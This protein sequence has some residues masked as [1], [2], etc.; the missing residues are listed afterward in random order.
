MDHAHS[1]L[2]VIILFTAIYQAFSCEPGPCFDSGDF[3]F[4]DYKDSVPFTEVISR[5]YK[6]HNANSLGFQVSKTCNGI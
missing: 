3:T 4:D 6:G 2:A 1:A 5:L